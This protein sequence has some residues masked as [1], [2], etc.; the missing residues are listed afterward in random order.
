MEHR[1]IAQ[2]F[3]WRS[4]NVQPNDRPGKQKFMSESLYSLFCAIQENKPVSSRPCSSEASIHYVGI[5]LH[6]LTQA[7]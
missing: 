7:R 1:Q 4:A 5:Y 2:V 6:T 3:P